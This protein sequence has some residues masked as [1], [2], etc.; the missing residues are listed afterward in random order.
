M[1]FVETYYLT[2]LFLLPVLVVFFL[3]LLRRRH[4]KIRKF[5]ASSLISDVIGEFSFKRHQIKA[6]LMVGVFLFALLALARPQWGFEWREIK[7]Q[8][9]D[10]LIVIDTSKSMLTQDVKP[11][12]LERTKFAVK[13]LIQKL[14]GDRVGLIA[15]AGDA[16]LMCPLTND[17]KGFLLSLD[18]LSI[19]SVPRGGTDLEKAIEV[20]LDGYKEIESKHKAVIIITDG[21][22]LEGSPIAMAKQAKDKG[23]KIFTVGVGTPEGELI[24]IADEYG[25]TSYLKDAKGNIVKSR[26]NETLLKQLALETDGVY[27]RSSGFQFGLDILYDKELSKFEK[28]EIKSRMEKRFYERFQIPLAIALILLL[29]EICIPTRETKLVKE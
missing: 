3:W 25:N 15:F 20:A 28:R 16:F 6:V 18:E 2:Y 5:V 23:V 1:Q 4:D 14:K 8:G 11:N 9:L 21:D 12:R 19:N 24:Q 13:D 22:N 26:L 27:V 17:Y 29:F 7:R 10:I